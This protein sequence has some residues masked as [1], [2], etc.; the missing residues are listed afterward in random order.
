[1]SN[2]QSTAKQFI[3]AATKHGINVPDAI[4]TAIASNPREQ[5]RSHLDGT[6]TINEAI[7]AALNAGKNPATDKQVQAAIT[8]R[9]IWQGAGDLDA[10]HDRRISGAFRD[11]WDQIIEAV[12]TIF[13]PAAETF[14]DAHQVLASKHLDHN[15]AEAIRRAGDTAL[16]AW[17]A[18]L[19]AEETLGAIPAMLTAAHVT[20]N[21]AAYGNMR[22]IY[23]T[24][25]PNL[26]T[27]NGNEQPKIT[28]LWAVL[29]TDATLTLARTAGE[30]QQRAQLVHK[31]QQ[32]ANEA[33]AAANKKGGFGEGVATVR[34]L[35]AD[36]KERTIDARGNIR[37][38]IPGTTAELPPNMVNL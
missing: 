27:W 3:N 17:A 28:D 22:R 32:L 18:A 10:L 30:A 23:W 21:P 15:D 4:T 24:V 1:M 20:A 16:T 6:P 8:A 7:H 2:I 26:D 13:A 9:N 35:G 34:Y 14:T 31:E 5:L 29:D 25:L 33:R 19:G 11:S 36:G 12:N 38:Y 37:N